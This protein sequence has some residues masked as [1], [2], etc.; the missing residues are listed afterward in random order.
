MV[1]KL[2]FL[3]FKVFLIKKCGRLLVII[4]ENGG[5]LDFIVDVIVWF[6]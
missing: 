1:R 6:F 5:I 2:G 4:F 3:K